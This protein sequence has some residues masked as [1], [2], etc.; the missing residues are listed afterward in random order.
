MIRIRRLDLMDLCADDLAQVN[1]VLR[2]S[3]R[4]T[5]FHTAEWNRLLIEEFGLRHVALL[6]ADEGMP[7]GLYI[8]FRWEGNI[9]KSPAINLQSVY[10]GPIAVDDSP[11]VIRELL[12]ESERREPLGAFEIWTPPCVDPAPFSRQGYIARQMYTP[13][14]DL[15][16]SEEARWA[17]FH[18]NKRT[19]IRKAVKLGAMVSEENDGS[20]PEY[21]RM[22]A[23]TLGASGIEALPLHFYENVMARLAPSGLARMFLVRVDQ[24][25]VSGTIVL[26]FNGTVYGWDIGWHREFYRFSPNDLLVWGVSRIASREG[27]RRFDLLRIEPDRLPGIAKWKDSFGGEIAPCY[28]LQKATAG[29]RL[30]HPLQVL[31]TEPSRAMRKA[32]SLLGMGSAR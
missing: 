14:L 3:P 7:V 12:D 19:T 18:R 2:R 15:A 9:C 27:Y 13:V 5:A 1:E 8:Y 28:L 11:D 10:G 22:V 26:C 25:P 16:C 30:F 29:F 6:A 20:L 23:E 31:M 32:K 17:R 21:R 24:R 4:A